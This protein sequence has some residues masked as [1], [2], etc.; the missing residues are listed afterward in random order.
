[1]KR[2]HSRTG[3]RTASVQHFSHKSFILNVQGREL[4][5]I[6]FGSATLTHCNLTRRVFPS[7]YVL[8]VSFSSSRLCVCIDECVGLCGLPLS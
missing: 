2:E 6:V 4:W 8:F 3:M 5:E 7:R 1:M